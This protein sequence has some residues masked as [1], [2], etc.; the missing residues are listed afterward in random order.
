MYAIS[1]L[2]SIII[3]IASFVYFQNTAE[4]VYLALAVAFTLVAIVTG[5]VFLSSKVN[6]KEDIHITD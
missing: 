1:A 2:V 5:G 4:N 6:K 3:A